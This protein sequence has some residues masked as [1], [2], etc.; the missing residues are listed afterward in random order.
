MEE[1]Y[2]L[3]AKYHNPNL[4]NK[5]Q[6]PMENMIYHLYDDGEI[7]EQKGGWAYG[8]RTE[9]TLFYPFPNGFRLE[10][11]KFPNKRINNNKVYGF[12]ICQYEIAL[13]IKEKVQKLISSN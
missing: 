5:K 3:I 11:N 13:D 8:M 6:Q 10:T 12:I 9:R 1:I 2:E 4:I 7:T